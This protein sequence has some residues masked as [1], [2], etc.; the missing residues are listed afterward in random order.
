MQPREEQKNQKPPSADNGTPNR[1]DSNPS[2]KNFDFEKKHEAKPPT[3]LDGKKP[4]DPSTQDESCV[5][6][7]TDGKSANKSWKSEDSRL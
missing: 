2:E 1:R 4:S 3:A 6:C 5:P 7:G